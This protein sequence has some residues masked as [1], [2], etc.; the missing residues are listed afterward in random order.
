M[1]NLVFVIDQIIENGI[2][3]GIYNMADDA[4]ISTNRLIELIAESKGKKAI[5][6][7]IN[8]KLI[9]FGARIGDKIHLP[10]NTERLKKLT[11]SYVV[12]NQKLKKALDIEKMPLSA[13]EGMI[14]TLTSFNQLK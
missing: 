6:W 4:P 13:E 8:Q 12:S 14:K 7:R 11:E 5:I 2:E 10:L 1:D 9:L 3:P